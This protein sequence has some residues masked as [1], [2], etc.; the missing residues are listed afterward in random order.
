MKSYGFPIQRGADA[1]SS[2]QTCRL[3]IDVEF[4][5]IWWRNDCAKQLFVDVRHQ[6]MPI[7]HAAP[8][9]MEMLQSIRRHFDDD[10]GD[11]E[12][13]RRSKN[14]SENFIAQAMK[15]GARTQTRT[16]NT[17]IGDK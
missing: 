7:F 10:D 5:S 1:G 11:G 14:R 15:T 17:F 3:I 6:H 16:P 12:M 13:R 8:H 2:E 4:G 9:S